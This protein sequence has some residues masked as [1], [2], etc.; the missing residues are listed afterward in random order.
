M[1]TA[2]G[3]PIFTPLVESSFWPAGCFDV[4]LEGDATEVCE[5]V[6]AGELVRLNEEEVDVSAVVDNNEATIVSDFCVLSIVESGYGLSEV[7]RLVSQQSS[8]PRP[9][10]AAPA[11]HQLLP[12]WSQ[13]LTSVN[14]LN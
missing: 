9:C 2:T 11:Q 10:P 4:E 1:M 3:T 6:G 5:V 7:I 8:P 13:R 12:F 14:F